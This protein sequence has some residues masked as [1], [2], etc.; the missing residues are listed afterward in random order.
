VSSL[1]EDHE[2]SFWIATSQGLI[3]LKNGAFTRYTTKDG[4]AYNAVVS[5]HEDRQGNLW[6]GTERGL[7]RFAEE[8]LTRIATKAGLPA[9][10]V[11]S[12]HE[13]QDGILWIGTRGDGL[14]RLKDAQL[15]A[16]TTKEGLLDN[17]VTAVLEDG[18]G[19]LWIGSFKGIFSVSKKELDD[20]DRGRIS[21]IT[22]IAYGR[23]D[24]MRNLECNSNQPSGWKSKDGRL[25][26]P[27]VKGVVM[28]DPDHIKLNT[29][30]PPVVIEEMIFDKKPV[31]TR[32][33]AELPPGKR[34]L[35]FHYSGLSFTDP[36]KV[37]FKYKL[38]GYD[39]IWVDAGTRRV[40][41]YTNIP[42]GKYRFRVIACNND[43]LWNETGAAF[44]FYLQHYWYE[45]WWVRI[46]FGFALVL[47]RVTKVA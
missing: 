37:E 27:T 2:G 43:G 5:L 28:I 12:I 1:C 7:N 15:T 44:E 4:L 29:L 3:R 26:F 22:S 8:R 21:S 34:E 19:H 41:Y 39:E 32:Q 46:L 30:P 23:A 31:D 33:Q 35:E 42:P 24:G 25:W 16:Y 17:V 10:Q 13:D 6:I 45:W 36:S 11:I 18:K 14:F 40:A 47:L 9:T 20:L 38:E